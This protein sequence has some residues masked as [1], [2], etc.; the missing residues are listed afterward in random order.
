MKKIF[1][2]I[3]KIKLTIVPFATILLSIFITNLPLRLDSSIFLLPLLTFPIIYFWTNYSSNLVNA[4]II[5]ILGL[6]KDVLENSPLG[7]NSLY[8]LVFQIIIFSQK[9]LLAKSTSFILIWTEYIFCLGAIFLLPY[10]LSFL[11]IN[12]TT[13]PFSILVLQWIISSFAYVPIHWAMNFL[14]KAIK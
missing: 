6:T 7:T 4:P 9:K 8:F 2:K 11:H 10:I 3:K 14:Y 12:L 13:L 5:M 1:R